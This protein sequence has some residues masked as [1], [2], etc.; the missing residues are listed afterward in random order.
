MQHQR[1][2]GQAPYPGG[3]GSGGTG[4]GTTETCVIT[5][6][7]TF[8]PGA[9][10]RLCGPSGVTNYR[11]T[12]PAGFFANSSCV[13]VG[14]EGTYTLSFRDRFGNLQQCTH[15]LDTWQGPDDSEQ[16]YAENCP[17]TYAFWAA[18]CRGSRT[19]VSAAE[20]Q[21]I[22]RRVDELSTTFSWA[23]DAGGLCQALRP[24]SPLTQRKQAARQLA[25]L[26]AN[27]A[28]AELG[29]TDRN[30]RMIGLDPETTI[31]FRNARTIGE[32]SALVDRMLARGRGSYS[33]ANATMNSVNNGRGIG[34]VCS[35]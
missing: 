10:V 19:D 12:G 27:V 21:S 15:Y 18:V 4:S 32:L 31:Q 30:G 26:L 17:R 3:T 16:P 25:A 35:E 11:W 28:A 24:A 20:L 14:R 22:A 8:E 23:D 5:G 7:D 13:S 6:P 34:S 33:Q 1:D 2:R 29:V 9:R